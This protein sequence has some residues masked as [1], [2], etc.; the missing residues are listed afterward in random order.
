MSEE[1]VDLLHQITQTDMKNTI[2]SNS[3]TG[4]DFMTMLTAEELNNY[5]MELEARNMDI[6]LIENKEYRGFFHFINSFHFRNSIKGFGY[7][8][9]LT[10]R[11]K[12]QIPTQK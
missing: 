5:K 12:G 2:T 8:W 3:F 6:T 7:W 1:V 4:I 10:E 11:Y 9:R